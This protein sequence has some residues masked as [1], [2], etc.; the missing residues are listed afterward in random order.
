MT[1]KIESETSNAATN[2]EKKNPVLIKHTAYSIFNA[3][4]Y[5]CSKPYAVMQ[6]TMNDPFMRLNDKKYRI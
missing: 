1:S 6:T 4:R 2:M 5:T 3:D